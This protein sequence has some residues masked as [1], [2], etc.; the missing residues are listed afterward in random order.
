M[1]VL[2]W[3]VPNRTSYEL[4]LQAELG[5]SYST[6]ESERTP[7][8]WS[9]NAWPRLKGRSHACGSSRPAAGVN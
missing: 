2:K 5:A 8:G 1:S 4:H 9:A 3:C 6:V 7:S